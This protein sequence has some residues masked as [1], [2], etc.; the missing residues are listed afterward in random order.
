MIINENDLSD[1]LLEVL[2]NARVPRF[3]SKFN[4]H[5]GRSYWVFEGKI[6]V[7]IAYAIYDDPASNHI[8]V[9]GHCGCVRPEKPW[10]NMLMPDG[11][12]LG[13]AKGLAILSDTCSGQHNIPQELLAEY[14]FTDDPEE[15]AKA[16]EFVTLYHIDNALGLRVF[17]D[18]L[19]W[20]DLI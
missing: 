17:M 2:H 12:K 10:T 4:L 3:S 8:R 11:T 14:T 19:R 15:R 20:F 13:T 1:V 18:Y 7:D 5:Y 9:A 6:P 16:K